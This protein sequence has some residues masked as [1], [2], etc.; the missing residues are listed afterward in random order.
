MSWL[1]RPRSWVWATKI[2]CFTVVFDACV[3]YPAPPRDLLMRLV[4]TD[5]YRTRWSNQ[6]H[7][8]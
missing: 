1:L 3:L 5:L 4:L 7:D 2:S 6:I 8:E